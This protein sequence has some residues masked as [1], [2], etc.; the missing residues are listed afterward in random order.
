[1]SFLDTEKVYDS[2]CREK[3][4]ETLEI[5]GVE[6]ETVSRVK[7]MYCGNVSCV[8]VGEGRIEWFKQVCGLKQRSALST[9]LFILVT[10]DIMTEVA[11]KLE[12]EKMRA[13]MFADD[14][15]VWGNK[16]EIQEQ[17]DAWKETVGEYR[18]KF[19]ICK[20]DFMVTSRRK[21]SP[22]KGIILGGEQQNE[23]ESFKYP[24]SVTEENGR[25]DKEIIEHVKQV[26]VF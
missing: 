6:K 12:E 10:D 21:G 2:V 3:V 16:E 25:N 1:M 13:M 7:Q 18:L 24:G 22:V 17:L 9:L 26:E 19:N 8:S 14:L 5:K 11:G 23:V 20:C 15:M 4:W